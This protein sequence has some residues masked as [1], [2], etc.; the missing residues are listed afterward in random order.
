MVLGLSISQLIGIGYL[1]GGAG[2]TTLGF[3]YS[4]VLLSFFGSGV[5]AISIYWI[6]ESYPL[7]TPVHIIVSFLASLI[8]SF[9]FLRYKRLPCAFIGLITATWMCNAI[10]S[11]APF[12]SSLQMAVSSLFFIFPLIFALSPFVCLMTSTAFYGSWCIVS[13]VDQFI[14]SGFPTMYSM[15]FN[16][17]WM[18]DVQC[19]QSTF[20]L[21]LLIGSLTMLSLIMQYYVVNK[22][23]IAENWKDDPFEVVVTDEE[24]PMDIN[25]LANEES[26]DLLSINNGET[27]YCDPT[28]V[29]H[30]VSIDKSYYKEKKSAE[31]TVPLV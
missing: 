13:G 16:A 31:E 4:D 12:S 23:Y 28:A 22:L 17:K 14:N 10:M 8:L 11:V 21:A 5:G 15:L 9:V 25:G 18:D 19:G 7:A 6:S 26:Q 20:L 30:S 24:N 2:V 3:K 29:L 27:P 1:T